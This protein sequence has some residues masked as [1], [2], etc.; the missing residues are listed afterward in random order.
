MADKIKGITIEIDGD[1]TKLSKALKDL[2]S[3]LKQ[4][5]S[6]LKDIDKLLRF[7]PGNTTL[8]QQKYKYLGDEIE[9]TKEKLKALKQAESQAVQALAK[10][11]ITEQ[12]FEDC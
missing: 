4:S 9:A 12:E 7:D 2:N 5:Q 1:T 3:K 8:L 11:D 6:N 10:G